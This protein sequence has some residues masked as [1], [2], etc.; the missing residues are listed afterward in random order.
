MVDGIGTTSYAYNSIA[1]PPALGASQLASIDASLAND[2]INFSYD[3]L[4]R[5]TNRS[6]N[7]SANSEI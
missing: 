4:D 5:V 7:R 6:V 3:Q 2:T 1:V